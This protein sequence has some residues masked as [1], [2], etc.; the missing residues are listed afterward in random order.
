MGINSKTKTILALPYSDPLQKRLNIPGVRLKP[1]RIPASGVAGAFH[2]DELGVSTVRGSGG[3]EQFAV[4][5]LD[6]PVAGAVDK[7][8]RISIVFEAFQGAGLL[9]VNMIDDLAG[10]IDQ[11]REKRHVKIAVA[12]VNDGVATRKAARFIKLYLGAVKKLNA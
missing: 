8:N 6:E 5:R 11:G 2:H 12:V 7:Q 4:I 1:G 3:I 9:Q 10:E